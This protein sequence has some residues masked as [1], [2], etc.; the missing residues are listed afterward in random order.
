MLSVAGATKKTEVARKNRRQY[1]DGPKY[2]TNFTDFTSSYSS[3]RIRTRTM[4]M[5]TFN[6]G[7][8]QALIL[9]VMTSTDIPVAEIKIIPPQLQIILPKNFNQRSQQLWIQTC[10]Q[11][12]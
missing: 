5:P 1:E 4:I 6:S 10:Y 8:V 12:S 3:S 11:T 9:I 2:K 7:I